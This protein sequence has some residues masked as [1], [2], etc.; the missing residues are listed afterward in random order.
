MQL[1]KTWM[2]IADAIVRDLKGHADKVLSKKVAADRSHRWSFAMFCLQKSSTLLV[3]KAYF[4]Q[5]VVSVFLKCAV[6]VSREK[7]KRGR[8]RGLGIKSINIT[9]RALFL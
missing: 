7:S 4:C 1:S 9:N 2:A 5:E 3:T 8:L 6:S